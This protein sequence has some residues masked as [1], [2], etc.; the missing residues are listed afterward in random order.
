MGKYLKLE[1]R[2]KA[3]TAATSEAELVDQKPRKATKKAASKA[4]Q[5]KQSTSLHSAA[6]QRIRHVKFFAREL[7]QAAHTLQA[8]ELD[9]DRTKSTSSESPLRLPIDIAKITRDAIRKARTAALSRAE[10]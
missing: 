10:A 1:K 3:D 4:R 8:A 6:R 2:E 5:T 9:S 7:A